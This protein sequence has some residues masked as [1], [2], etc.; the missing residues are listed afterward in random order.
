LEANVINV[1]IDPLW[2]RAPGA[3]AARRGAGE[4]RDGRKAVTGA[5]LSRLIPALRAFAPD[6]IMLSAG[7]DA[8][9]GDVGNSFTDAAG[10][11]HGGMDMAPDDFAW[12]TQQIMAVA[13]V[14]CPGRVVSV[15][16]GGY[17]R[18]RFEA[19]AVQPA[20]AP[21]PAPH[22]HSHAHGTV[23]HGKFVIDRDILVANCTAHVR[24]LVDDGGTP[25]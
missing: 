5:V 23:R 4:P 13:R 2:L 19:D 1:P 12:V 8:G 21:A 6:L 15:L 24:A 20:P 9:K 7:F 16:E 10:A 14:C 22:A 25:P 17:G 11:A 3:R 18:Y